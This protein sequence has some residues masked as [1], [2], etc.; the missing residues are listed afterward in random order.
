MDK[1][2][3]SETTR[4]DDLVDFIM[5]KQLGE[6]IHRKVFEFT[7]NPKVVIKCAMEAPNI[8]VLESEVWLMVKDTNIAKWFAPCRG[9]SECGIYL[10]QDR[11]EMRPRNEYPKFVPSFFGDLK[12]SNFG[13]L[14]GKFVCCDYAGFIATSM[15]HKWS[16][17]MVKANF[18]E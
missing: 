11:V 14:N 17:K 8:N 1:Q 4:H 15:C 13:W 18:W 10:L 7:P 2:M 3:I 16:G 12:Y 6:G 9:T 5:G